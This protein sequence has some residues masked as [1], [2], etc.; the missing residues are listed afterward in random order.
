M[1]WVVR[2]EDV[3]VLSVSLVFKGS[4]GLWHSL[5]VV[6]L[7]TEL[8]V[9]SLKKTELPEAVQFSFPHGVI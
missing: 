8:P 6:K 7:Y 9:H 3:N 4:F 2:L 1:M 5:Y